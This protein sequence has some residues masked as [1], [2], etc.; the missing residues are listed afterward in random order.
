MAHS[1]NISNCAGQVWLGVA[2]DQDLVP[3]PQTIV[4]EFH[5]EF[6]EFLALAQQ[7]RCGDS[8]KNMSVVLDRALDMLD[9]LLLDRAGNRS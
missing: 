2:T 5:A 7:T 8:V 1:L 4:S 3:D 9:H 6:G